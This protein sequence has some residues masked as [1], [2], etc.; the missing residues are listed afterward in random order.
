MAQIS[1]KPRR[2]E[3]EAQEKNAWLTLFAHAHNYSMMTSWDDVTL[4]QAQSS[5]LFECSQICQAVNLDYVL[6]HK[7]MIRNFLRA[8][9]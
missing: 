6:V 2:L 9:A 8:R 4:Q 5:S 7:L 1:L 3:G